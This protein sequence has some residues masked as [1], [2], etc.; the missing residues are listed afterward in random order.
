MKASRF[1]H[2]SGLLPVLNTNVLTVVAS[3]LA[4]LLPHL[5]VQ[6]KLLGRRV[7]GGL[8]VDD[9]LDGVGPAR[10]LVQQLAVE[11]V[12]VFTAVHDHAPVAWSKQTNKWH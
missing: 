8:A 4:M 6:D 10:R 11:T 1:R 2:I 7:D 5:D 9:V 12:R 3:R